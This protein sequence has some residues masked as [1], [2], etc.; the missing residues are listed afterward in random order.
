VLDTDEQA[1]DD[2]AATPGIWRTCR[3]GAHGDEAVEVQTTLGP[4]A[5]HRARVCPGGGVV[6][7][8]ILLDGRPVGTWTRRAHGSAL[9]VTL[10]P[11][12]TLELKAI[13]APHAAVADL[14]RFLGRAARA[15]VQ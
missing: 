9:D 2:P 13:Q 8:C 11:W 15:I 6:R 5:E 1:Q 7:P 14:G 3:P 4:P 12:N 10:D